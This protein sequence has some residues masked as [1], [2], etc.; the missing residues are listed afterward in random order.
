MLEEWDPA[1]I[2]PIQ[3]IPGDDK[4]WSK[5]V[6]EAILGQKDAIVDITN[7]TLIGGR[8]CFIP[9]YTG[10]FPCLEIPIWVGRSGTQVRETVSK[11]VVDS[12]DF[13]KGII[14]AVHNYGL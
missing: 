8:Q 12:S 6:D 5:S 9:H 4:A 2:A 14:W 10:Q 3:D 13:R 1:F 11:Q 7:V